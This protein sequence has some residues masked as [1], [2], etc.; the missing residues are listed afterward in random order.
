[1]ITSAK[2]IPALSQAE[3]P[4]LARDGLPARSTGSWVYDKKYYFERYLDIFTRGVGN[5][6]KGQLAYVDFFSGPGR[7]LIRENC[8]EVEGS[9]LIALRYNFARYVFV[10]LPEVIA[11]LRERVKNNPKYC[12]ITLI[13]G[14]CNTVVEDIRS[15]LPANHL[16]LAFI[17]PT[18]VQIQFQTIKRFV[19]NRKVD[20]LMTIQ[21]GMGIRMNLRQYSA[22]EKAALSGFLGNDS[23]REDVAAGGTVS[24]A[25]HQILERYMSELRKL[26]FGVVR[27]IPIRTNQNNLLLYFMVLASRHPRGEDFWRKITEIQSSGQRRLN[28]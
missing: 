19:E 24:D 27:E 8:E 28:L 9:P 25:S 22:A 26:G 4:L 5:K 1:M 11:T 17:D 23:W 2:R 15:A 13:E 6:W 12:A 10:D 20:L 14:D 21:F 16:T 7:S 18:G 3:T